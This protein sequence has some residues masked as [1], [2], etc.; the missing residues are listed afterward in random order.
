IKTLFGSS[1]TIQNSIED[2]ISNY[3]EKNFVIICEQSK[4]NNSYVH[5]KLKILATVNHL[6]R[7][8]TG[9]TELKELNY[10]Q[11]LESYR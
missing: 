4:I 5:P 8:V 6:K 1:A 11:E 3:N 9:T 10:P 7:K 2:A